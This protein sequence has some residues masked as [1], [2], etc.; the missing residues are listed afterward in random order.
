M[1]FSTKK[2]I[3]L[4]LIKNHTVLHTVKQHIS[5]AKHKA[6]REDFFDNAK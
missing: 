5:N 1:R 2:I 6:R 4:H 3:N